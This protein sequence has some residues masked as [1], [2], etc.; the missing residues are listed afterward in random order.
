MLN[1]DD[2]VLFKEIMCITDALVDSCWLVCFNKTFFLKVLFVSGS[3]HYYMH[4]VSVYPK[5]VPGKEDKFFFAMPG[6]N[7][8][9]PTFNLI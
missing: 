9:H 7:L 2:P 4:T 5:S 8:K 3:F 1:L 6:W